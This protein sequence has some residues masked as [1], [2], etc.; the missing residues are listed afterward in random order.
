MQCLRQ[1]VEQE[2]KQVEQ[3]FITHAARAPGS[4]IRRQGSMPAYV[5]A[6]ADACSASPTS[7]QVSAYVV[8]S[9]DNMVPGS[10]RMCIKTYG[11]PKRAT[12]SPALDS[13]TEEG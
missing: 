8:C 10:P 11:T 7:M 1:G 3:W 4:R 12:C 13:P 2:S 5:A 6:S 9:R